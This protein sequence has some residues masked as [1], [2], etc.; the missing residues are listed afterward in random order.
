M[1]IFDFYAFEGFYYSENQLYH[2]LLCLLRFIL[3]FV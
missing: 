3:K 1:K 2:Y